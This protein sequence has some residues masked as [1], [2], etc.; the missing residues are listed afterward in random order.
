MGATGSCEVF[1]D[2][3]LEAELT[4][5]GGR[6]DLSVTQAVQSGY[7]QMI[8]WLLQPPRK[9][10][11]LD[12]LGPLTWTLGDSC[13]TRTDFNVVCN[14]VSTNEPYSVRGYLWR[15]ANEGRSL[16]VYMHSNM[17][18]SID[19]I[20]IRDACLGAGFAFAAFDFG[21]CGLSTGPF[22]TGGFEERLQLQAVL[23]TLSA[24]EPA[25]KQVFLWG[26]SLGAAT[27]LEFTAMAPEGDTTVAGLV[28]DS[29]Y[30]SLADMIQSCFENAKSQGLYLPGFVLWMTMALARKSIQSRA[31]FSVDAVHPE[32][33]SRK[34]HV[35]ALFFSG[36]HDLYVP[37]T[38][39]SRVH[40]AYGG[41][42]TPMTFDGDHYGQR[43]IGVQK[44][45][46][47][48]LKSLATNS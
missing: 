30:T 33:A 29:P 21:G 23:S 45:A 35:P 10:Y 42:A 31:G 2:G 9:T 6:G 19:A 28:L 13:I 37:P 40:D 15:A 24:L 4:K 16:V 11:T 36:S 46:I 12:Q 7:N 39:A 3:E 18:S 25:Y 34:C 47:T 27:A 17:A 43:P 14:S 41:P 5:R 8:S 1:G 22:V 48:F 26:H 32:N 38:M 20:P 44:G